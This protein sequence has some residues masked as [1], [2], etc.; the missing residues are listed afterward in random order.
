MTGVIAALAG[1][2]GSVY[3]G[4]ATV[5]VGF[6]SSG[7]F[8]SYGFQTGVKG[9]VTPSTWGLTGVSFSA[10]QDV[11]SSGSPVWLEFSVAGTF[12]NSGWSTL[13]INGTTLDRADASYSSGAGSSQWIF[14]GAPVLFG[15]TVGATR[16]ATWV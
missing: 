8:S 4:S 13:T 9:S 11:Y 15:T 3:A 7:S 16:E 14:F 6:S 2:R 5:T 12:P 10:L 1:S